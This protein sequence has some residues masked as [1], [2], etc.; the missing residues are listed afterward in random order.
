MDKS[1]TAVMKGM[2]L[3]NAT[4]HLTDREKALIGL[5]ITSTRGCIK[6]TGSRIK[7]AIDAGIPQDT[8][9][10]GIDLAAMV[11]AGVTLAFAMQGIENEGLDTVCHDNACATGATT[12]KVAM[13]ASPRKVLAKAKK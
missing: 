1:N 11:N 12:E 4:T 13:S 7:K 2:D 9:M 3:A 6:C 5:A 8:I 10:A